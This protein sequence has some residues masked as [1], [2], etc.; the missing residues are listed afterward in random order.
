[1]FILNHVSGVKCNYITLS[2]FCW[3]I[4]NRQTTICEGRSHTVRCR[5]KLVIKIISA[6][7]G[8]TN[9]R[10]CRPRRIKTTKCRLNV[11]EKLQELCEGKQKCRIYA[12]N[13]LFGDPC[14]G[15]DKYLKFTYKCVEGKK[16]NKAK[17]VKTVVNLYLI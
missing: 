6:N 4:G 17:K 5:N 2:Y 3:C 10:K 1:M 16:I 13:K 9:S 15:I 14:L 12:S 11:N 8:R 7:Y